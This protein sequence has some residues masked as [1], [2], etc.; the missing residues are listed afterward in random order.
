MVG[1]VARAH[2]TSGNMCVVTMVQ[3][4]L[5]WMNIKNSSVKVCLT[6]WSNSAVR[7]GW[8]VSSYSHPLEGRAWWAV[9]HVHTPHQAICV[10]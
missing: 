9:W 2:T 3:V 8:V 10:W 5:V 7:Q 6:S 1:G 4:A